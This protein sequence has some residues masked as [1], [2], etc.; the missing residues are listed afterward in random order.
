M[1]DSQVAGLREYE[2][3]LRCLLSGEL[4]AAEFQR[5]FLHVFQ[6]DPNIWTG[7]HYRTLETLFEEVDA[8]EANS[9]VRDKDMLDEHELKKVAEDSLAKITALLNL[10]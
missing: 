8:F 1:T 3:L 10:A 9:A 5:E 2:R 7:E 4:S 6:N